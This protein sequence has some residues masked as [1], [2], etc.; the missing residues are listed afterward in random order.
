[1]LL[2]DFYLLAFEDCSG[3]PA[4][5]INAPLP[6]VIMAISQARSRLKPTGSRYIPFRK[7]RKSELGRL[8]TLTRIGKTKLKSM[9]VLGGN[10]KYRLVSIEKANVLDQKT[11]KFSVVAIRSEEHTSELQS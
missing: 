6:S 7:K 5:F 1:M 2:C 3:T 4:T 8:P 11:K 9:R 10:H